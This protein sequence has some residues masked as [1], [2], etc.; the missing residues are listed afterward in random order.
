MTG[1]S[2]FLQTNFCLIYARTACHAANLYGGGPPIALNLLKRSAPPE[3]AKALSCITQR[4]VAQK[5]P[6]S[7]FFRDPQVSN[8]GVRGP[9][10]PLLL[11]FH[12][13][14]CSSSFSFSFFPSDF[15]S[16]KYCPFS[17]ILPVF[18][19]SLL[20]FMYIHDS[21]WE[22]QTERMSNW[23]QG[24]NDSKL[25]EPFGHVKAAAWL[26]ALSYSPNLEARRKNS[27]LAFRIG[28]KR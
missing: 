24:G 14:Y 15:H 5:R 28:F 6:Y 4:N 23:A 17:A 19:G 12:S 25:G 18:V 16:P 3:S 11:P 20:L 26:S 7:G 22:Q 10:S 9:T 27:K 13:S 1:P 21:S 2:T 8:H